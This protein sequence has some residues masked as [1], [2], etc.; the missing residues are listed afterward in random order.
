MNHL[1]ASGVL[2]SAGYHAPLEIALPII[3][4]VIIA[5][6]VLSFSRGRRAIAGDVIVRC[7]KGHVFRTSWSPLGSLTSIRLGSARFQHCPVGDHW[8]LVRPVNDAD[9]TDDDRRMLVHND[10]KRLPPSN[11]IIRT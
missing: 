1:V 10:R 3:A 9:L 2:A 11:G 4:V 8:S 7:G 5:K 6:V